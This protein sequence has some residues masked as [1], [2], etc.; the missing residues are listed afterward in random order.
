MPTDRQAGGKVSSNSSTKSLR[1]ADY[2]WTV[3]ARCLSWAIGRGL[4]DC[5]PLERGGRLYRA[6]RAE[7]VWTDDEEAQFM[8]VASPQVALA[9][10]LAIWTGQRQGDLLRLT[11][12]AYDGDK[13]RLRQSKIRACVVVPVAGGSQ[14][15][16]RRYEEAFAVHPYATRW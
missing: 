2:A 9:F 16:A 7:S 10:S 6:T 8:A 5:N 15:N 4:V 3:F 11:W 12:T 13:I 14:G 1:Q